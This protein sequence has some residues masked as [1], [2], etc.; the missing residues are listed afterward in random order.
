MVVIGLVH[1]DDG[2]SL[3][4][5][6]AFEQFDVEATTYELAGFVAHTFGAADGVA[7][8]AEFIACAGADVLVE[9]GV[10]GEQEGRAGFLHALRDQ[11]GLQG[12]RMQDRAHAAEKGQESAG[13]EA[14]AMEGGQRAEEDVVE[15]QRLGDMGEDL[16]DVGDDVAVGKDDAFRVAFGAGGEEDDGGRPRIRIAGHGPRRDGAESAGGFLPCSETGADVFKVDELGFGFQFADEL[17]EFGFLDERM[18]GDDAF[19]L[20]RLERRLHIAGARRE[21]QHGRDAAIGVDG[22]EGDDRAGAGGQHQA[23]GFAAFRVLLEG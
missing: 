10:G 17:V 18:G 3:S 5:A 7:E 8:I 19:D 6:V 22:E 1:R 23:D 4:G 15:T 14:E 2:G 20:R 21:V 9:E 13:S 11:L 16:M 12:R